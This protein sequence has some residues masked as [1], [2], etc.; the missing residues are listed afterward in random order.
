[1][2]LSLQQI[3][4]QKKNKFGKVSKEELEEKR[5]PLDTTAEAS[6]LYKNSRTYFRLNEQRMAFDVVTDVHVRIKIYKKEGFEYANFDLI[7]YAPES[8][9]SSH[10]EIF[11]IK[12]YTF[13]LEG[14]KAKKSKL[15]SKNIFKEVKSKYRSSQ[16]FSMP[17]IKEGCIVDV[18]YTLVSPNNDIDDLEFQNFIPI[19][20]LKMSVEIPEYYIFNKRSKGYY[21]LT[22][23]VSH[24]SGSINWTSKY[25]TG[26][27]YT[28]KTNYEH[29]TLDFTTEK[30][31]YEATDIPALNKSEPFVS[32]INNYRGGMKYELSAI[33]FPSSPVENYNTTWN[34]VAKK[35]FK[36]SLF[37]TELEKTN[38]FKKDLEQILATAKTENEK[39]ISI[40]EF[41]KTKM[42]WNKYIGVYTDQGVK[43]A[44]D[45]GTGNTADINLMLVSMLTEA[46][47]YASPVLISTKS[48]G[49]PIF[50]TT[51]GYNYVIAAVK[52]LENGYILL[53]AT[54]KYSAPNQLPRRA[55]NW[56]GR[57]VSKTGNSKTIELIPRKHTT[58]SNTLSVQITEDLKIKG[59]LKTNLTGLD[60]LEYRASKNHLSEENK[61]TKLE[62]KYELEIDKYRV[63][64]KDNVSKP[65]SQ[66]ILFNPTADFT[67]TINNKIYFNPLFFLSSKKN[68]FK[69]EKRNFPVDF[70]MPWKNTKN[71]NITLPENLKIESIPEAIG[72]GLPDDIG[73]F[74]FQIKQ[75]ANALMV[76]STLQFNKGIITPEYYD[77]L[78]DFFSKMIAKQAEKI[79]LVKK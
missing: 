39:I 43:K 29:N 77:Y 51:E 26:D 35:I 2:L 17:N 75:K 62:K 33:S 16:K 22:P 56:K 79:V 4:A 63:S 41:V 50:P 60:A 18:K 55:L 21:F 46:G 11:G 57:I 23:Q 64:N 72:I 14:G 61:I 38:Y 30:T 36:S 10:E 40:F 24:K 69:S 9:S 71:V 32:N 27:R 3:S 53:D 12:G 54:Q 52:T 42:T 47:L 20:E 58:K 37:G 70:T 7:Y 1:M 78:K 45:S 73:F 5:H 48:N 76:Q 49:I 31:F 68:P 67:E 59:M 6:Y 25:R 13:N 34:D 66:L 65:I 15:S 28:S 74:K 8:G 19:K 44:Y